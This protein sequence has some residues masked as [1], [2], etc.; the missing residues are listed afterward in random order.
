MRQ[1][2]ALILLLGMA[3]A[4]GGDKS[5]MSPTPATPTPTT[6]EQPDVFV[7][8]LVA[9]GSGGCITGATV[10]VVA[11]QAIGQ[12]ATQT[13]PCD[14]WD[15]A[16]GVTFSH[17]KLGENMTLRAS[18]SGYLSQEKVVTPTGGPQR[19]VEFILTPSSIR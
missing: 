6:P 3:S 2:A 8:A 1:L 4:C 11:G 9:Q 14:V 7:W 5:P 16:G 17:L 13:E 12:S 19:A 18:A 10:Q 15:G